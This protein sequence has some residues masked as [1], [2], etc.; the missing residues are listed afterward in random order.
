MSRPG[1]AP[2]VGRSRTNPPSTAASPTIKGCAPWPVGGTSGE[3]AASQVEPPSRLSQAPLVWLVTVRVTLA[4]PWPTTLVV[5]VVTSP[6]MRVRLPS[7]AAYLMFR[8]RPL[9]AES[10]SWLAS[11][12]CQLI[13]LAE[14]KTIGLDFAWS[15]PGMLAPTAMKPDA[16]RRSTLIWSPGCNGNAADGASVQVRP[17][18][19]VQIE[20]GPTATHSPAPP[21]TKRAAWPGGGSPPAGVRTDPMA[22]RRP[23]FCDTKN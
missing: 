5:V 3:T 10:R 16:V 23:P 9:P 12:R 11:S 4:L 20:P 6:A 13:P 2:V 18:G 8:T 17:S 14:R 7:A 21:A 22:Q 15:P 19:L 1:R